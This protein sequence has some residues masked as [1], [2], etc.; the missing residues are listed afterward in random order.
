[1][2]TGAQALGTH[3]L[4]LWLS[5]CSVNFKPIQGYKYGDHSWRLL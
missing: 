5:V 4:N 2:H 1:M 3:F